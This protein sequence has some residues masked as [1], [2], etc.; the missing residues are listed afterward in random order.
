MFYYSESAAFI[1]SLALVA[2]SSSFGRAGLMA[3]AS[4][5]ASAACC[6]DTHTASKECSATE[7]VKSTEER[8]LPFDAAEFLDALGIVIE[9]SKQHFNPN[10]RRRGMF[11]MPCY[12][13]Y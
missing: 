10:Y 11:H 12:Q 3:L 4:C 5:I 9:R 6:C 8:C 1:S 2:T 13:M 7:Q